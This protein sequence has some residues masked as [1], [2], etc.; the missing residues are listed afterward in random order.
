MEKITHQ[1]SLE[2]LTIFFFFNKVLTAINKALIKY[3]LTFP[4]NT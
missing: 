3:K 2:M 4:V 1:R